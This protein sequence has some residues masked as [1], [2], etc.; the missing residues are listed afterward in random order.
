MWSRPSLSRLLIVNFQSNI[1]AVRGSMQGF[2]ACFSLLRSATL[3]NATP[4]VQWCRPASLMMTDHHTIG[5][6]PVS[7]RT[8][9]QNPSRTWFQIR[10]CLVVRYL[11]SC[12]QESKRKLRN[13]YIYASSYMHSSS[14]YIKDNL[15]R[16]KVTESL[17]HL[18]HWLYK[19]LIIN[20]LSV[21]KKV[22]KKGFSS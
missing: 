12:G 13:L 20:Y 9:Q 21:A 2:L 6:M 16:V 8:R 19:C 17:G 11:R 10:K 18:S 14:I 15:L 7:K 1:L 5:V 22:A 3:R 4:P